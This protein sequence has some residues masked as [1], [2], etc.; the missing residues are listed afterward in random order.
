MSPLVITLL[1]VVGIVILIVIGYVNHMV[2]NSKLEKARLK[3]DL[4]DRIRRCA[5]LSE[6][7]PGQMV[8]PPSSCC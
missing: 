5:D 2:E 8:S 3:A 1:I 7:L 4:S 6:T